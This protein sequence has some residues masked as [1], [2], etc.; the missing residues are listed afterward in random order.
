QPLAEPDEDP[1][2]ARA[3]ARLQRWR[4]DLA[5][6]DGKEPSKVLTDRVLGELAR[7]RPASPEALTRIAGFGQNQ[8]VRYGRDVLAVI[9]DA[10]AEGAAGDPSAAPS[11][12]SGTKPG[13]R[14]VTSTKAP[15]R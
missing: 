2:A 6:A 10:L 13:K 8:L 7:H 4:A 15:L 11:R 5:A 9:A 1:A 3:L 12:M 14:V